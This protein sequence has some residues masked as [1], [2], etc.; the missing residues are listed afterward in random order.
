[1]VTNVFLWTSMIRKNI[2]AQTVKNIF[3]KRTDLMHTQKQFKRTVRS[4]N[5]TQAVIPGALVQSSRLLPRSPRDS[6][7]TVGGTQE[8]WVGGGGEHESVTAWDMSRRKAKEGTGAQKAGGTDEGGR[9]TEEDSE[10]EK[11]GEEN[12]L[13]FHFWFGWR[14]CL[15][16]HTLVIQMSPYKYT[17]LIYPPHVSL[18]HVTVGVHVVKK[19]LFAPRVFQSG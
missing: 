11:G 14:N 19:Q 6:G 7:V 4:S 5:K 2:F 17:D 1:M 3:H 15:W 18:A 13:L 10:L 12:R 16:G 8:L 9:R